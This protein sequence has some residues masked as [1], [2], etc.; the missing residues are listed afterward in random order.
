[1]E[2]QTQ[3]EQAATKKPYTAP[4][5]TTHGDVAKLTQHIGFLPQPPSN[6]S[7]CMPTPVTY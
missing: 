1:M 5:L 7:S 3:S 6:H 2:M 4:R